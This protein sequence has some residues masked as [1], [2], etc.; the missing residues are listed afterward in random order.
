VKEKKF[1]VYV[2][3]LLDG[4]PIYVGKGSGIRFLNHYPRKTHVGNKLRSIRKNEMYSLL[5]EIINV[6]NENAAFK[7][8]KELISKYGRLDLNTGPLYNKTSGGDG[9][10]GRRFTDE[11]R[12]KISQRMS[13]EKHPRYG[14]PLSQETKD[15]I[16]RSNTG[17]NPSE[18][19]R[20]KMRESQSGRKHSKETI[21]K[22]R[23][24]SAGRSVPMEHIEYLRSINLGKTPSEETRKKMSQARM[25]M[26]VSE[27]SKEKISLAN[28]GRRHSE[29]SKK[30]MSETKQAK[31]LLKNKDN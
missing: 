24:S 13:G 31:K 15:K 20:K 2:Y 30:K 28:K 8:E 16:S 11:D 5:P 12:V 1:Y 6:E 25:G 22:M 4:T 21:E 26:R 18:E 3:R 23:V 9:V 19:A 14:K 10:S 17:K 29:Y 27:E 7:L